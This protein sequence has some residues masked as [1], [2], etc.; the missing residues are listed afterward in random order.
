MMDI[1]GDGLQ[2]ARQFI[3]IE[4][5][6]NAHQLGAEGEGFELFEVCPQRPEEFRYS[7]CKRQI[8]LVFRLGYVAV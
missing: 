3:V 6:C 4:Q 8:H 7:K 1:A 5:L 2:C